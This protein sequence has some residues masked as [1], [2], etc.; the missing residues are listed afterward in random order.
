MAAFAPVNVAGITSDTVLT[1]SATVGY[2]AT[3]TPIGYVQP[4]IAKWEN[5]ASG[6]SVGFP[7]L[8]LAV[9]PPTKGSRINKVSA[10]LSIPTLEAVSGANVAGLTPAAQKAYEVSAL[11]EFLLPERSTQAERLILINQLVALLATTITASDG[12]PSA[13]TDSPVRP[14]VLTYSRPY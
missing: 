3:Y 14:A 8:T 2:D 4:G 7:T 5:Q 11:L 6:I 10:R 9:R 1:T 12:A 13:S